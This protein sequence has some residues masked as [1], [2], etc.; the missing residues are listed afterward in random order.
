MS[1]IPTLLAAPF[2]D[3]SSIE[4]LIPFFALLIPII[5]ILVR[6]QQRMTELIHGSAAQQGTR[7]DVASLKEQLNQVNQRLDALT[8]SVDTLVTDTRSLRASTQPPQVAQR[9]NDL[10][11]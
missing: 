10:G 11:S 3:S 9:L 6:H 2:L 8:L 5:A 4:S 1:S 7:D